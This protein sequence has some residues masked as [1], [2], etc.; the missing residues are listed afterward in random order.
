LTAVRRLPALLLVVLAL[1]V[2]SSCS[3][4]DPPERAGEASDEAPE[5]EP[6]PEGVD[7]VVVVRAAS[8]NHVEG[9]VDYDTYPPAG[10]DHFQVWQNCRAYDEPVLDEMAVH[11]LEH[12]AVWIAYQDDLPA[13]QVEAIEELADADT[14]I[15]ASP[16]PDLRVPI[17][18]TAWERQL[19]L[20]SI[21]DERFDQFID[22]YLQGPTAPEPGVTCSGGNDDPAE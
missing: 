5:G 19:D 18:L 10:G 8:R 12:G 6:A 16:Y 7:G 15:L 3:E 9:S 14:H 21:D 11:S 2:A 1:V 20:D 22:A 4:S 17:V 13:D